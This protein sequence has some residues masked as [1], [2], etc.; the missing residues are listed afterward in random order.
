MQ[1]CVFFNC[2]VAITSDPV[3]DNERSDKKIANVRFAW[4]VVKYPKNLRKPEI[5]ACIGKLFVSFWNLNIS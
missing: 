4:K 3:F 1:R 5:H 2:N